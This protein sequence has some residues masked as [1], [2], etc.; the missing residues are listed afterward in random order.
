MALRFWEHGL[1]C[2]L[3]E[4]PFLGW[5][6]ARRGL[7]RTGHSGRAA[8]ASASRPGEPD[9]GGGHSP[10]PAPCPSPPRP[11]YRGGGAGGEL[12]WVGVF[13]CGT[14]RLTVSQQSLRALVPRRLCK[15]PS[16]GAQLGPRRRPEQG[17]GQ[18]SGSFPRGL[19]SFPLEGDVLCLPTK[20]G[21]P[22]GRGYQWEFLWSFSWDEGGRGW[23]HRSVRS[24][25]GVDTGLS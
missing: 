7:G 15:F 2:R 5:P 25:S 10:C 24:P 16:E 3:D 9:V 14:A 11:A 1:L 18:E 23:L 17:W 8:L 6:L 21:S 20:L 19:I 13:C 22:L 12:S 4:N